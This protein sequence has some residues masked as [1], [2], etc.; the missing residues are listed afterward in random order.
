MTSILGGYPEHHRLTRSPHPHLLAP[1]LLSSPDLI[2]NLMPQSCFDPV[3]TRASHVVGLALNAQQLDPA[4]AL[5]AKEFQIIEGAVKAYLCWSE[6]K[7]QA[8]GVSA[9]KRAW[10]ALELFAGTAP[11]VQIQSPF[12]WSVYYKVLACDVEP[13]HKA[14]RRSELALRFPAKTGPQLAEFQTMTLRDQLGTIFSNSGNAP[15]DVVKARV[16]AAT[17]VVMVSE[18]P[19]EFEQDLLDQVKVLRAAFS[20]FSTCDVAEISE[21]VATLDGPVAGTPV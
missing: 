7:D 15:L 17:E 5:Q 4:T 16:L 1:I 8:S 18:E 14:L 12:V 3:R 9:F 21:A 10:A 20:S 19:T 2:L 6:R 13:I 11:A